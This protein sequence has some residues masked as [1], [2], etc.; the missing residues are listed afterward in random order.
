[1]LLG[2]F[3]FEDTLLQGL[4]TFLA[5]FLGSVDVV[6][7]TQHLRV[8]HLKVELLELADGNFVALHGIGSGYYSDGFTCLWMLGFQSN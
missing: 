7:L 8:V 4:P 2:L 6:D 1:M 3:Q 5:E